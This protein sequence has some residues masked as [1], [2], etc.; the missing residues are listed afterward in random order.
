MKKLYLLLFLFCAVFCFS[1][2][3][4]KDSAK[5]DYKNI[6][7]IDINSLLSQ[8]FNFNQNNNYYYY[9]PYIL[10]YRRV[11]K[12]SAIKFAVGG[13]ASTS[14]DKRNDSLD[15]SSDRS[16]LDLALGFE[17]YSYLNKRWTAFFGVDLTNSYTAN[18]SK[19]SWSSTN[20]SNDIN[21]S[22]SYGVAPVL[23]IVFKITKRM[24]LSTQTSYNFS[25]VNTTSSRKQVL[26]PEYDNTSI[27][28][29]FRTNF[30][31]PTSV[32]FRLKF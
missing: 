24:S 28:K 4:V 25:Y 12:N 32:T 22:T 20:Y 7:A 19:Y 23:G 27:S 18:N 5:A 6:I 31:A 29:G 10:S 11:I 13:G 14:N 1:Q 30:I 21:K 26:N 9:S 17:H 8:F 3:A 15:F 16:Q 2:G